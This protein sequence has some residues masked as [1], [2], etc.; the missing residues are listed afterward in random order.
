MAE[1]D[2]KSGTPPVDG[3]DAAGTQTAGT[4]QGDDRNADAD[5]RWK[6]ALEW[7]SKAERLNAMERELAEE[8]ALR[9]ELE[10]R[11]TRQPG[12][13]DGDE[14]EDDRGV[15]EWASKN[16]VVARKVLKLEKKFEERERALISEFGTALEAIDSIS[17]R[18][19]RKA[20]LQHLQKN[21]HRLGDL[22]AAVAEVQGNKMREEL[23]RLRKENERLARKP[24]PMNDSAP[25][26]IARS[27]PQVGKAKPTQMTEAA[28]DK[29][30]EELAAAKQYRELA[31]LQSDFAM[32]RIEVV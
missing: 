22:Q 32:G 25:S 28:Y 5:G 9:A 11:Q 29:R 26:T 27:E 13:D 6:E 18:E 1:D 16:D 7:K 19:E 3:G 2:P 4:P 14:D 17:D 21:R 8:R 15:R 12:R 10:A 30:C 24:E 31:K 20:A 23:E